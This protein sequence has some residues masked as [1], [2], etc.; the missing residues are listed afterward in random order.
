MRWQGCRKPSTEATAGFRHSKS[1]P[2]WTP[3][4]GRSDFRHLIDRAEASRRAALDTFV[5]AGGERL[6]G[7]PVR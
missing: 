4:R 2:G 3:L 6:L 7:V 1:I 5:G